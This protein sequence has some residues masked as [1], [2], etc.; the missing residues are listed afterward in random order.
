MSLHLERAATRQPGYSPRFIAF[1]RHPLHAEAYLAAYYDQ[2]GSSRNEL[3]RLSREYQTLPPRHVCSCR[4]PNEERG[5]IA[6]SE[7]KRLRAAAVNQPSAVEIGRSSPVEAPMPLVLELDL[8][9]A[10]NVLGP[11]V[12][13][14]R[15]ARYLSEGG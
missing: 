7:C 9:R 1:V 6:C 8:M 5:W 3:E 13:S 4:C 15:I 14:S 11:R 2:S 12:S 10:M